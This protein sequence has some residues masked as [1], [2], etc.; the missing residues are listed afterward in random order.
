MEISIVAY[1]A[2][3]LLYLFSSSKL[4]RLSMVIAVIISSCFAF[5]YWEIDNLAMAIY[6]LLGI[7]SVF[8][9]WIACDDVDNKT[10]KP[11]QRITAALLA[12]ALGALGIHRFY[13]GRKAT[14]LMYLLFSWTFIPSVL[15]LI[16]SIILFC[17]K[18]DNFDQRYNG[19]NSGGKVFVKKP[20]IKTKAKRSKVDASEN[21]EDIN[22][23]ADSHYVAEREGD[24]LR[25]SNIDLCGYRADA[26]GT[27][28]DFVITVHKNGCTYTFKA[29][30][31]DICSCRSSN[32][33]STKRYEVE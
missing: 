14:G 12:L 26:K 27:L 10:G 1:I 20:T 33:R 13:L 30:D 32:M 18:D 7:V 25:Y 6:S 11:K 2:L 24:N 5:W 8:F 22:F 31:G 4:Q 17:M 29:K 3:A 9:Y 23:Y 21:A 19:E 15:G 28:E 16:E